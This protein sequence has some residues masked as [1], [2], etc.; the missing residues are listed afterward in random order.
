[1]IRT[2]LLSLFFTSTCL[3]DNG[4]VI[5]TY[6]TQEYNVAI[7]VEPWP[8]RVGEMQLRAL[9]TRHD[10]TLVTDQSILPFAG[11]IETLHIAEEGSLIYIYNLDGVEQPPIEIEMFPKSSVFATYWQIWIFLLI[12]LI[13]IILREF[14]AKKQARRY[15]NR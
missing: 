3:A 1:M 12:G 14:L 4:H 15:P 2:L 7:F 8:V 9:V 6:K 13:T 5:S 11:Q 10:G